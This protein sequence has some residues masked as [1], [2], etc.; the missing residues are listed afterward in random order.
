MD[1][2]QFNHKIVNTWFDIAG[3]RHIYLSWTFFGCKNLG[4]NR[5]FKILAYTSKGSWFQFQFSLCRD[6]SGKLQHFLDQLN[7]ELLTLQIF[8]T[9]LAYFKESGKAGSLVV[10]PIVGFDPSL[11]RIHIIFSVAYI[12]Y[13]VFSFVV[14]LKKWNNILK[15]ISVYFFISCRRVSHCDYVLCDICQ[16]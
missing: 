3:L 16:I 15:T 1:F 7:K 11:E 5:C 6:C 2:L 9:K 12:Y 8:A 4:L 14:V 13:V 10:I